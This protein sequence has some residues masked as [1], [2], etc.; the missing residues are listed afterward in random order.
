MAASRA[1]TVVEPTDDSSSVSATPRAR[2]EQWER[3]LHRAGS[4][5]WMRACAGVQQQATRAVGYQCAGER[6][7]G[8]W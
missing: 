6:G 8:E 7:R 3:D 4:D 5:D 2:R 1:S